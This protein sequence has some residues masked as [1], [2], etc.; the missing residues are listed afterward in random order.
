M[1]KAVNALLDH[2]GTHEDVAEILGYTDRQYRNIRRKIERKEELPHRITSL[3]HM[4][5]QE[6]RQKDEVDHDHE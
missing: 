6:I 1:I 5:F 2:F 4:K 3:I